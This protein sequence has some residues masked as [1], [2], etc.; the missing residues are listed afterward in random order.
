MTIEQPVREAD[1]WEIAASELKKSKAQLARMLR[2]EK[3]PEARELRRLKAQLAKVVSA[4]KLNVAPQRTESIKEKIDGG[5]ILFAMLG[6]P[7]LLFLI[8]S[9]KVGP[10][11]AIFATA[12]AMYL[13]A[14]SM[15]GKWEPLAD[16]KQFGW[17]TI[18]MIIF[19]GIP[20]MFGPL[21]GVAGIALFYAGVA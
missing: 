10:W 20:G 6:G 3:R 12:G 19:C 11:P 21:A 9:E 17:T 7:G 8:L 16:L 14:L 1:E 18:A 2:E 5:L 13:W 4:E 15:G